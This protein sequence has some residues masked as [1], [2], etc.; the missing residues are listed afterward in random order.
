MASILYKGACGSSVGWVLGRSWLGV[1][2]FV[3]YSF[4]GLGFEVFGCGDLGPFRCYGSKDMRTGGAEMH[5]LL[6]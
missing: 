3:I 6:T 1:E 4:R 5:F 2:G